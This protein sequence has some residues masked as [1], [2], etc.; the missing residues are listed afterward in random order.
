MKKTLLFFMTFVILS[1]FCA[2][3]VFATTTNGFEVE[4]N[5]DTLTYIYDVEN[6]FGA[7]AVAKIGDTEY[8][9]L[10]EAIDAAENGETITLISDSTLTTLL[11]VASG[12]SIIIDLNGH[13]VSAS[14]EADKASALI[15]N[16]GT[17]T[18]ND[19]SAEGTGK[20]TYYSSKVSTGYSTSTIINHG[21]LTVNG[22]TIENTSPRGG[23]PYAIDSYNT[24]TV[25]GGTITAVSIAIRQPNFG[26]QENSLTVTGGTITGGYA[27]IQ[28]H[29]FTSSKKTTTIIS[30]GEITGTYAFYS[31]FYTAKDSAVTDIDITNGTFNGYVFLYNGNAGSDEYGLDASITGGTY[32]GEVY[33]YTKDADGAEVSIPAVSGG[34]H[35]YDVSA[36]CAKGF[37]CTLNEDGTY[38]VVLSLEKAFTF[39]GYSVNETDWNSITAGYTIDHEVINLYCEEKGIESFDFGCAFGIGSINEDKTTS[40]AAYS[41]YELF[42]VKISGINPENEKHT[43]AQLVMALYIDLGEGKRYVTLIENEIAIVAANEVPYVV[44]KDFMNVAE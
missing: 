6:L 15:T 20:L 26:N 11:T 16:N 28:I 37:A 5:G 29:G 1:A 21:V 42:N 35:M 12:K 40:F 38:G 39:L 34:V 22:G 13:T 25:N 4:E 44:F 10:Q 31:S 17:L 36:Y 7:K 9:T 24:L 8:K 27:G 43:S 19:S 14:V 2:V 30:G 41:D 33:V 32:N 23:A 18:I 3:S